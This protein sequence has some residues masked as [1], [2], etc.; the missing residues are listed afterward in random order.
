MLQQRESKTHLV[1]EEAGEVSLS[2][3]SITT[4]RGG[5]QKARAGGRAAATEDPERWR[6][7]GGAA[8]STVRGR[9]VRP[10]LNR[11]TAVILIR[12]LPL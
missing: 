3:R 6:V 7:D 5:L 8:S 9:G 2:E 10:S 1:G 12:L 4:P 11:S